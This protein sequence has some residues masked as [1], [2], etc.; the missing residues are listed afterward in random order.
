[1][2]TATVRL[3][4]LWKQ[5]KG[6]ESDYAAAQTLGV[7]RGSPS[8]WR[9]G[10]SHAAPALVQRMASDIGQDAGAWLALVESERATT[11]ADRKAWASLARQLGAAA[12]VAAVA[13]IATPLATVKAQGV[14]AERSTAIC[15]MRSVRRWLR[16]AFSRSRP[17]WIHGPAAVLA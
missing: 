5:E 11:A 14:D 2:A 8:N 1:M 13:L 7:T 12:T 6:L 16:A 15:I 4:D 3:L 17:G 9:H 10:R